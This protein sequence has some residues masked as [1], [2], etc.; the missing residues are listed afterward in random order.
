MLDLRRSTI[1]WL[2]PCL[3]VFRKGLG[4]G[5]EVYPIAWVW[6]ERL[7]ICSRSA[8]MEKRGDPGSSCPKNLVIAPVRCHW[9]QLRVREWWLGIKENGQF[10][11][12]KPRCQ[13]EHYISSTHV[14]FAGSGN[15]RKSSNPLKCELVWCKL[16]PAFANFS[17]PC[18]ERSDRNPV[19]KQLKNDK[20]W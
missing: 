8:R 20:A 9:S 12:Q 19:L 4:K 18:K 17:I 6:I 16:M 1:P 13:K 7:T 11:Y 2:L 15:L 3:A 10:Q 5:P 14:L